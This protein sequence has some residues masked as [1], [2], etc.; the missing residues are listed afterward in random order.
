[1]EFSACGR[2]SCANI[3]IVSSDQVET[4]ETF[5]LALT[6]SRPGLTLHP[7]SATVHIT[8]DS[9]SMYSYMYL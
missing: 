7:N 4:V 9:S 1:M 2:Q 6:S 8:D 5:S 3:D